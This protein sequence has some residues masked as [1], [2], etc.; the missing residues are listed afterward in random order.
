[1]GTA[2]TAS[3]NVG[4]VTNPGA[5]IFCIHLTGGID[6]STTGVVVSPELE[7][8]ATSFAGSN[9]DDLSIAEWLDDIGDCTGNDVVE[10]R[11]GFQSYTGGVF[12]GNVAANE[13]FFFAVP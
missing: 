13:P 4:T 2:V 11:T 1:V 9:S 12:A 10:V 5:G 3:K 6:P 8:G 7:G